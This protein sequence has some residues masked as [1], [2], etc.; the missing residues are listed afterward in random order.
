[1]CALAQKHAPALLLNTSHHAVPDSTYEKCNKFI[2]LSEPKVH[3]VLTADNTLQLSHAKSH[4][5]MHEDERPQLHVPHS[6]TLV[7]GCCGIK[8]QGRGGQEPAST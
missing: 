1:M 6:E 5:T 3:V 4:M 8:L 7:P 2:I